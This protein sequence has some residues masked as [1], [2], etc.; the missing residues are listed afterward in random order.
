MTSR[1]RGRPAG[2]DRLLRPALPRAVPD[3]RAARRARAHD[4]G[5]VHQAPPAPA[6]WDTLVRAR[7]IENQAFVVAADQ[8]GDPPARQRELRRLPDR[9]S[10]G[11]RPRARGRRGVLRGRRPGPRAPGR[12]RGS[13]CRAWPT[14]CRRPTA[15]PRRRG[16]DGRHPAR[17]RGRQAP[18]DP[19]RRDHRVRAPGLPPLPRLRRGGRGRGGLR[20]RLPLLRLQGGDPQRALPRALADHARRDRRDRP[21]PGGARPRQALPGRQLHHRLLPPRAGPDEGDHRGGHARGQLVRPA[22]PGEDP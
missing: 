22:P 17:R 9:G 13:R 11:R 5:G 19:R 4:A 20:A 10:V 12:G 3:P 16:S 8:I 14:A 15:G 18:P 6:H 2:P 21:P 1:G 7:A